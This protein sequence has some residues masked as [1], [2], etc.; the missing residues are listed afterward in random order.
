M[1]EAR[2]VLN[3]YSTECPHCHANLVG[4]PIPEK[5]QDAFGATHFSRIIGIELPWD[6][7]L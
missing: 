5:D 6:D 3:Y 2:K 1:V 7:P 4:D